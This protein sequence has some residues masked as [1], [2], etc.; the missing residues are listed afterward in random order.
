MKK[1]STVPILGVHLYQE[2]NTAEGSGK[3]I[4]RILHIP[5]NQTRAILVDRG[6]TNEIGVPVIEAHSI[7]RIKTPQVIQAHSLSISETV[8]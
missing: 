2:I 6:I 4:G 5:T 1:I 8:P 7:P 3:I